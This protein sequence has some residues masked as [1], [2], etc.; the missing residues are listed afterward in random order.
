MCK[1]WSEE[2]IPYVYRWNYRCVDGVGS[3][4]ELLTPLNNWL[5]EGFV[6]LHRFILT[7]F[8]QL[9]EG[10]VV[11]HAR[12]EYMQH[13]P[14]LGSTSCLQT[15][16][17]QEWA[18]ILCIRDPW[19]DPEFVIQPKVV[20]LTLVPDINQR[21]KVPPWAVEKKSLI[22]ESCACLNRRRHIQ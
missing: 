22:I 1:Y 2:H 10:R 11:N 18:N 4:P 5:R 7:L 15:S 6:G 12:W 19:Y 8:T 9:A 21:Q 3:R 13:L 16:E 17:I 20:W 14:P